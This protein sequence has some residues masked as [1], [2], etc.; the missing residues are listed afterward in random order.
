MKIWMMLTL[1]I[2]MVLNFTWMVL[3]LQW[4]VRR[5]I[6]YEFQKNIQDIEN[7]PAFICVHDFPICNVFGRL[8][9][10]EK[11]DRPEGFV[12]AQAQ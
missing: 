8:L 5:L 10:A 2:R 6:A 11:V 3:F 4:N 12:F 7:K 1:V 9:V